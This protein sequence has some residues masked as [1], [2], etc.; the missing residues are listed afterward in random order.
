[1]RPWYIHPRYVGSPLRFPLLELCVLGLLVQRAREGV[2]WCGWAAALLVLVTVSQLLYPLL[3]RQ[4]HPVAMA[5][6]PRLSRP[7]SQFWRRL[8]RALDKRDQV[9]KPP[10][11]SSGSPPH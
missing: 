7:P 8:W 2:S 4:V 1:M 10:R 9:P 6:D 11:R 3:E 5:H